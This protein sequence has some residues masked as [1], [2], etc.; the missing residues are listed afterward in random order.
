VLLSVITL[1]VAIAGMVLKDPSRNIKIFLIALAVTTTIG[2]VITAF[3]DESDRTFFKR[4]LSST[5]VSLHGQYENLEFEEGFRDRA[6][7][8]GSVIFWT[9]FSQGPRFNDDDTVGVKEEYR[10]DGQNKEIRFAPAELKSI[11]EGDSCRVFYDAEQRIHE[12]Y[13]SQVSL[14]CRLRP[15]RAVGPTS[16]VGGW[17]R[18][19]LGGITT[20]VGRPVLRVLGEGRVPGT[21]AQR[22]LCRTD[23]S[24]VGGIATRPCKKCKDGAPSTIDGADKHHRRWA[25]RPAP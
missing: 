11:P 12:K 9:T 23:K 13:K 24:C 7:I 20:R 19:G 1:V 17:P 10:Q 25:T 5:P 3:G 15:I 22:V 2:T 16:R 8:L 6:A 21:H 18:F 4:A 14:P